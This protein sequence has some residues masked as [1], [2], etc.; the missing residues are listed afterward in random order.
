MRQGA[1]TLGPGLR[2]PQSSQRRM[3]TVGLNVTL[4]ANVL[5][6]SLFLRGESERR[7]RL[8]ELLAKCEPLLVRCWHHALGARLVED[9][10]FDAVYMTGFGSSPRAWVDPM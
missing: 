9:A 3:G 2:F 7:R 1:A 5:G 6:T 4:A 8:R 10:S